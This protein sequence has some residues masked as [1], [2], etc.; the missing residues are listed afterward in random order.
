MG[1]G[2]KCPNKAKENHQFLKI[3]SSGSVAKRAIS[4]FFARSNA[5]SRI[6]SFHVL[7]RRT[8]KPPRS[9]FVIISPSKPA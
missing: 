1:P 7:H 3:G 5:D 6:R 2:A 8:V 4:A 9:S